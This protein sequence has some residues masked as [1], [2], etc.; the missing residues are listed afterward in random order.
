MTLHEVHGTTWITL[1]HYLRLVNFPFSCWTSTY[2]KEN[3]SVELFFPEELSFFCA[4]ASI[5]WWIYLQNRLITIS[6]SKSGI[7]FIIG[8][9]VKFSIRNFISGWWNVLTDNK[10]N[11]WYIHHFLKAVGNNIR[12]LFLI[13][14]WAY[15]PCNATVIACFWHFNNNIFS[16]ISYSSRF[17]QW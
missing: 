2:L 4:V 17:W 11:I 12:I 16:V 5:F 10:D 15:W 1:Y 8:T 6:D 7:K 9:P 13:F 3:P 14:D